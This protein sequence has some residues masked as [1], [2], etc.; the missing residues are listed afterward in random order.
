M[1]NQSE[2]ESMSHWIWDPFDKKAYSVRNSTAWYLQFYMSYDS[3]ED[4][5]AAGYLDLNTYRYD[6]FKEDT[7]DKILRVPSKG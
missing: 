5:L 7:H 1:D 4:A 6:K 3:E 2:V